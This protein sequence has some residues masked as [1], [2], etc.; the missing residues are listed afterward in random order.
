MYNQ[1]NSLILSLK[2]L[3]NRRHHRKETSP[4]HEISGG[5]QAF[6]HRS[7]LQLERVF[8]DD[9]FVK[10]VLQV[11][12]FLLDSLQ[13]ALSELL[14]RGRCW[15]SLLLLRLSADEEREGD[16]TV[17]QVS[18]CQLLTFALYM[19]IKQFKH[20]IYLRHCAPIFR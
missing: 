16:M 5:F 9:G 11:L 2:K 13:I 17:S 3:S 18:D 14:L 4:L 19:I 12:Y 6:L 7:Q 8:L 1:I 10:L 20:L 15:L